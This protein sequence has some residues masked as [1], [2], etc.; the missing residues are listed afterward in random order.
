M[1]DEKLGLKT[2]LAC[3]ICD[4]RALT[5]VTPAETGGPLLRLEALLAGWFGPAKSGEQLASK[6]K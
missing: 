3:G 6:L 1:G 2:S 4:W 5:M